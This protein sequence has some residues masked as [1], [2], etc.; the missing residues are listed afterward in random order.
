MGTVSTKVLR[1]EGVGLCNRKASAAAVEE[2]RPEYEK[3]WGSQELD[4][5]TR[6]R[7]FI[8]SVL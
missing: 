1:W 6:S 4:H 2:T 7:D 5:V 3:L 8:P